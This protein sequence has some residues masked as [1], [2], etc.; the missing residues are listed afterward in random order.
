[1]RPI[2]NRRPILPRAR[3][4]RNGYS[5]EEDYYEITLEDLRD[6]QEKK[7]PKCTIIPFLLPKKSGVS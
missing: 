4:N 5:P 3:Q 2:R 1:M 6:V 7:K